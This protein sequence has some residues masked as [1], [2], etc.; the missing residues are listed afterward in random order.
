MYESDQGDEVF[1]YQSDEKL[2]TGEGD[3][4][5]EDESDDGLCRTS[6]EDDTVEGDSIHSQSNRSP[7][8]H[9][10][11]LGELESSPAKPAK[12]EHRQQDMSLSLGSASPNDE[13]DKICRSM[14][15]MTH[16]V[17]VVASSK[18]LGLGASTPTATLVSKS[19]PDR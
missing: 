19:L 13:E 10:E 7:A 16:A 1:E 5:D 14:K 9:S 15:R 11:V 3:L 17:N 12:I 4:N 8:K 2:V 18:S 6:P